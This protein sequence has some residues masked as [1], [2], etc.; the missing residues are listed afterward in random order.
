MKRKSRDV[1]DYASVCVVCRIAGTW[2]A[3]CFAVG[4]ATWIISET[5]NLKGD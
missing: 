2:F 4:M 1:V 3:L 5:S